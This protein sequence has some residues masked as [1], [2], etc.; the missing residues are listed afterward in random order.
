MRSKH[1]VMKYKVKQFNVDMAPGGINSP[2]AFFIQNR[3]LLGY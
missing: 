1:Q 3:D 2:G